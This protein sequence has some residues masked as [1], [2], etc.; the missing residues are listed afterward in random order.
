MRW[1]LSKKFAR[2]RAPAGQR[3]LKWS[4]TVLLVGSALAVLVS[5]LR[6]KSQALKD[7]FALEDGGLLWAA[8]F[9]G[10]LVMVSL[11]SRLLNPKAAHLGAFLSVPPTWS[12]WLA[13]AGLCL[14]VDLAVGLGSPPFSARVWQWLLF[15]TM[16]LLAVAIYRH[17]T[18]DQEPKANVEP[19][20]T[21]AR[22]GDLAQDWAALERWLRSEQPANEDLLGHQRIARRLANR[23]A[24]RGGRV[25]IAGPFGSGKTSIVRWLKAE[26]DR[27]PKSDD[28]QVWFCELSCWGFEDSASAVEAILSKAVKTVGAEADCFSIRSLPESYRKVFSAG[29]DWMRNLLDMLLGSSDHMGQFR[30]LADILTALNARLVLVI[31][32][33]DRTDSTKFDRQ[34]VL[35]LLQRLRETSDRLSFVLTSGQTSSPDINFA[36]LCDHV[37]VLQDFGPEQTGKLIQAVRS[38]CLANPPHIQTVPSAD[39]PWNPLR[40]VLLGRYDLM[41]LPVV[42]ARLL[43][44][45]RSLKHALRRTYLAWETLAGEVDLDHLLAV[46]VL[47]QGASRAFD[48]LQS[49]REQLA[50]NPREW[51]SDRN[52]LSRLQERLRGEWERATREVDW[53]TRAA[54]ELIVFLIPSA[55]E[56][57][58]D[59]GGSQG[60]RR[61]GITNRYYWVRIVNEEIDPA[62]TR[63]QVV[64]RDWREW[65]SD[66]NGSSALVDRL[67]TVADYPN[68]WFHCAVEGASVD[69]ALT[70]VLAGQVLSH[71]RSSHGSRTAG[72]YPHPAF[73]TMLWF[74]RRSNPDYEQMRIWLEEQLRLAMSTS[75]SLV[76]D[77]YHHWASTSSGVVRPEGRDFLR[78]RVHELAREEIKSAADLIR[79]S[80]PELPYGVYPLVFPPDTNEGPSPCVGVEHWTWLGP[81][82]AEALRLEPRRFAPQVGRLIADERNSEIVG[83][84]RFVTTADRLFGFFGAEAAAVV[85]LLAE[86]RDRVERTDREFLDQVVCSAQEVLRS[87][88]S[89]C[90]VRDEFIDGDVD[91]VP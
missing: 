34:E 42:A 87:D 73:V 86:E 44:T 19:P 67:C 61:Q 6:G 18:R 91:A 32:D 23:I 47:R 4:L 80:H 48:F 37:E 38:H 84:S 54:L 63:D 16:P 69:R 33:L 14:I 85:R 41:P 51:R 90:E 40:Y 24:I 7:F 89:R 75:L 25:G 36:K 50:D 58:R 81:I 5:M 88:L 49:H 53:D 64:L 65:L 78:Y 8:V 82:L 72:R 26:V 10:S 45:P 79:I 59:R 56:Y 68:V 20:P 13:G 30:R 15:G 60:V 66:C 52:Q 3:W 77:L 12:A 71:M 83:L 62:H 11:L 39:D 31:E 74:A 55:G 35:A 2:I 46:N 21:E 9:I 1:N 57:L 76:V 27:R 17:L 43:K 28:P 70:L 29:G 22:I